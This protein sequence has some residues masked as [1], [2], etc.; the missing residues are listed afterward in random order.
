MS[1]ASYISRLILSPFQ[2]LRKIFIRRKAKREFE[3]MPVGP[4]ETHIVF[5]KEK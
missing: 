3:A 2:K 1:A 5:R 4:R